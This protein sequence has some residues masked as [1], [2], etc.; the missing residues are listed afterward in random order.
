MLVV[1]DPSVL[2][3]H[4]ALLATAIAQAGGMV[5][6]AVATLDDLHGRGTEHLRARRQALEQARHAVT[7]CETSYDEARDARDEARRRLEQAQAALAQAQAALAQAQAAAAAAASRS[8]EG[9]GGGSGYGSSSGV[10]A[11]QAAVDTAY[12]AVTAAR[13][14]YEA[15]GQALTRAQDALERARRARHAAEERVEAA[16]Q[17]MVR[18]VDVVQ[19]GQAMATTEGMFHEL[20]VD[21]TFV[22]TRRVDLL[23]TYLTDPPGRVGRERAGWAPAAWAGGRSQPSSGKGKGGGGGRLLGIL[24]LLL[25]LLSLFGGSLD[26]LTRSWTDLPGRHY[27]EYFGA[28]MLAALTEIHQLSAAIDGDL[29]G[30]HRGFGEGA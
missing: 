25:D 18:I 1:A 28:P 12:A 8:G 7:R 22:L 21:A 3:A 15:A 26:A 24:T 23:E 29:V 17:L 10:A 5:L 13:S 27:L 20:A 16:S 2:T 14:G 19:L 9:G 4:V 6:D 30:I 11:A